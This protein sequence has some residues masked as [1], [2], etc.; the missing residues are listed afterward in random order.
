MKFIETSA[1]EDSHIGEVF[2]TLTEL[3]VNGGA[4]EETK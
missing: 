3:V 4:L 2:E 1:K